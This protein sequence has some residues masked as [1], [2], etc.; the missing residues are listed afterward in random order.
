MEPYP[1]TTRITALLSQTLFYAQQ[2]SNL[3][4]STGVL[5]VDNAGLTSIK[6][7]IDHFFFSS[8]YLE[9]QEATYGGL[10]HQDLMGRYNVSSAKIY[11]TFINYGLPYYKVGREYRFVP[12]DV[13]EWER[14]QQKVPFGHNDFIFLPGYL[15]YSDQLEKLIKKHEN[16][17]P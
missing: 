11:S 14:L 8:T 2:A 13:W 16:K 4:Y 12:A 6:S 15:D 3:A 7:L 9:N 1:T 17:E 10:D 5:L